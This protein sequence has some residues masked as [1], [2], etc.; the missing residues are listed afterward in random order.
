LTDREK[1]LQQK[2][3]LEVLYDLTI[4]KKYRLSLKEIIDSY[5]KRI[6]NE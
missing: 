1:L 6:K 5:E 4:N 2:K 3:D